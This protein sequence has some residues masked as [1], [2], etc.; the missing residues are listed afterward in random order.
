MTALGPAAKQHQQTA[1][2][3]TLA[4]SCLITPSDDLDILFI[5]DYCETQ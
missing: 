3:I 1:T 4:A 5:V 2:P